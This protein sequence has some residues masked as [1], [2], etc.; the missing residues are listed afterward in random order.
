[1]NTA[2]ILEKMIAFS[3]GNLHDIDHLTYP[4]KG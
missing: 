2:P 3:R 1:M 4:A